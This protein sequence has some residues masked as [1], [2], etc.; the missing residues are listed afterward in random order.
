MFL[1]GR[2]NSFTITHTKIFKHVR[3]YSKEICLKNLES[4]IIIFFSRAT[5]KEYRNYYCD[6]LKKSNRSSRSNRKTNVINQLIDSIRLRSHDVIL[7]GYE[8]QS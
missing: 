1:V 8:D 7:L 4:V 6:I 2:L 5:D 3:I